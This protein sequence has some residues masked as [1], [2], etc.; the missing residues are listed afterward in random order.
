MKPLT[1]WTTDELR[2][3]LY[4][5]G[6][7]FDAALAELM[8]RERDAETPKFRD[9]PLSEMTDSRLRN[10]LI[11]AATPDQLNPPL[12]ELLRRERE[13]CKVVVQS[14][15]W[16][17]E[18]ARNRYGSCHNCLSLDRIVARIEALK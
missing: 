16:A 12:A 8:R 5:C 9:E 14:Q 13:R 11:V 18:C 1:E 3:E 7:Q 15:R 4:D 2:G 17:C 10:L 6:S